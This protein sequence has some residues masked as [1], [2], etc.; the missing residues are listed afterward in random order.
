METSFDIKIFINLFFPYNIL[1]ILQWKYNY[2]INK[3][4]SHLY[5]AKVNEL[6]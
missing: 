1:Y 6:D 4:F 5:F 2:N 3:N